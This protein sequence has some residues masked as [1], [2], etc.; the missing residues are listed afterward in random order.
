[1]YQEHPPPPSGGGYPP[2]QSTYPPPGGGY[3]QQ[4]GGYPPPQGGYP[5]TMGYGPQGGYGPT[6]GYA[7]PPQQGYG[8]PIP[9]QGYGPPPGGYAPPPGGYGPPGGHVPHSGGVYDMSPGGFG[10]PGDGPII[11]PQIPFEGNIQSGAM[12]GRKI[13][14]FG[15]PTGDSFSFNI[16]DPGGDVGLHFNPRLGERCVVRNTLFGGTWGHEEREG[17]MPFQNG[18]PFEC[19]IEFFP[20]MY[21]VYINK[22]MHSDFMARAAPIDRFCRFKIDGSVKIQQIMFN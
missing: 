16:V 1:M 10:P 13:I 7:P 4:P 8:P 19:M 12:P 20:N 2:Q 5:N 18:R 6:G 14:I 17:P 3:Q 22:S 15:V 9:Q 11:N 21:R